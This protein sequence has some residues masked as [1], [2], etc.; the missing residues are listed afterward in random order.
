LPNFS[1]NELI[2]HNTDGPGFIDSLKD[3]LNPHGIKAVILGA[4]GSAR[5]IAA[6]LYHEGASEILN[7]ILEKAQQLSSFLPKQATTFSLQ[8]DYKNASPVPIL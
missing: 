4:G 5:T 8:D 2:G 6:Q 1:Y 7:R 3:N